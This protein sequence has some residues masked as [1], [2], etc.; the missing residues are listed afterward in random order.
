MINVDDPRL[1]DPEYWIETHRLLRQ[2]RDGCARIQAGEMGSSVDFDLAGLDK[3]IDNT[4]RLVLELDDDDDR[5][6]RQ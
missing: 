4:A 6:L 1:R 5:M 3:T 2:I